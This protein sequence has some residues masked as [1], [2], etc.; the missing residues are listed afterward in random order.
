MRP[1]VTVEEM[2]AI[3]AA[4]PV[5]EHELIHRAAWAVSRAAIR[6]MGGTYGRRVVVIAGPGNNGADGV[7]AARFLEERGVRTHLFAPAELDDVP[8]CDLVIDAAFG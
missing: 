7:K 6:M 5:P 1:I 3:D 8:A 2:R 4:S